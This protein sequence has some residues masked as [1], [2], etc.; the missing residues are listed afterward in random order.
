VPLYDF[1]LGLSLVQLFKSKGQALFVEAIKAQKALWTG[2]APPITGIASIDLKQ[3]FS[4]RSVRDFDEACTRRAFQCT[5]IVRIDGICL[6][7]C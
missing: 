6:T 2:Q 4:S 7:L 1:V 5:W 3:V